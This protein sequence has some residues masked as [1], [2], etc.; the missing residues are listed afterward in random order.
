MQKL[1]EKLRAIAPD[2]LFENEPMAKHT[3]FRVG[4]PADLMFYPESR[5]D[6]ISALEA[7][8]AENVPVHVIGNGSNLL[9]RD[10]GIR[11][12]VIVLGDEYAQVCVDGDRIYAQAGVR[13][14][15]I[16][17]IAQENGLTGLEFA[18]GIPGTLGGGCMMLKGHQSSSH[19]GVSEERKRRVE[20]RGPPRERACACV[21]V[22]RA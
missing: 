19:G 8:K 4:G 13:L 5:E 22:R 1:A 7:A 10:G 15:R 3:T 21:C 18:G 20:R 11:G 17:G 6:I 2:R 16:A 14:S 9:V 12:L